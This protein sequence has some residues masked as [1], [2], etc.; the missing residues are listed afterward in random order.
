MSIITNQKDIEFLL[1]LKEEDITS[2]L[3]MELFGEFDGKRRFNPE[4]VFEVPPNSYNIGTKSNKNKFTTTVGIWVFN[5]FFISKELSPILGYI[6]KAVNSSV[7]GSIN[8]Q[9][10]QALMEDRISL[11]AFKRYLMKTQFFAPMVTILSPNHTETMM[12]ATIK[13]NK[14]KAQLL[15]ENKK[16]LE[17][18]D[19]KVADKIEKE[20][21]EY[22]KELLKDD[23][24]MDIYDSGARGSFGNN[25]KNL[26]IMKG[27]IKDP[28]PNKGYDI[29]TSSYLEGI[30]KSE[31]PVLAKSLA[32][33]PY[34]R[35]KKT[36]VGGY[37]EKQFVSALQH[38]VALPKGS[39]C[40]TKRYI[41]MTLTNSNIDTMMYSYMIE[42]QR[43]VRLDSTNRDKYIGKTVKFRF[44]SLCEAKG[45]ICNKC[46]GDMFYLTDT[47]NIGVATSS[48]PAK[49]KLKSMKSFHDSTVQLVDID[50]EEAFGYK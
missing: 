14:R 2:S 28:D 50:V 12:L 19:E 16:A 15:S 21:I 35:A 41:E 27:A 38:V 18:G 6:N 44:S 22:A 43:L 20:L 46:L 29:I 30:N 9:L 4:D 49:L 23:P 1:N 47:V 25:F 11:E 42:G 10:S 36:E 37:M 31:F 32:A 13:I 24:F 39:D 40:H 45:G 8:K 34:A 26:Y 3:L 7:Y 5:I 48:L 17:A 33:G